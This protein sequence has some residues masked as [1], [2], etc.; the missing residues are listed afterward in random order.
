MNCLACF[1]LLCPVI[2]LENFHNHLNQPNAKQLGRIS[3]SPHWLI[4]PLTP[5]I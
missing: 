4:N 2:G 1:A 3:V 5:M